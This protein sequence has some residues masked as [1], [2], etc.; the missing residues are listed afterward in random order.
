M[1]QIDLLEQNHNV[2]RKKA[3]RLREKQDHIKTKKSRV[4]R[5]QKRN[6]ILESGF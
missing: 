1:D 6:D 5:V 3:Q 2:A 4:F